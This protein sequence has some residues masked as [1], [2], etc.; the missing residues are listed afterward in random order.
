MPGRPPHSATGG[1][2]TGTA[3]DQFIAGRFGPRI[4][5]WADEL[6]AWSESPDGLTCTYLSDA[7]RAVAG[8]LCALMQKAGLTA[9]IDAVGNVVGRR[10]GTSPGARTLILGSHYDT[11]RKAGKYDGRFG[12][13]AAIAAMDDLRERGQQLPFAVEVIGFAEEEGARFPTAYLGSS[14]VA[15]KFDSA[16]LAKQDAAGTTLEEALRAAGFDPAAIAGLARPPGNLLGYVELHIEQGP[17]LRNEGLPVGVVDAIAGA[18]RFEVAISGRGGHAGTVPMAKRRDAV[19]VAAEI[20]LLVERRCSTA[21][22]LVGTVG[23]VLVPDSAVN[24]IPGRCELSLDIRA[25]EDGLRDAAIADIKAEIERIATRRK[26]GIE[27]HD[28]LQTPA[29]RCAPRL[30][31]ALAASVAHCGVP[32][33]RLVSGAGHD[34]VMFDGITDVGMLFVRCGNDGISHSADET[35]SAEDAD[36]AARVLLDFL[37]NFTTSAAF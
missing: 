34:A 15:G 36:L 13:L 12:I 7:H 23:Q 8:R 1:F 27:V 14:A 20:I 32:V 6:A 3:G 11:V 26:V 28:M 25:A 31:S 30:Q 16:V 18:T 5:A 29:V 4:L 37:T 10:E 2:V 22:G 35:I 17:V 33:R 21:A 24:A 19:A 9:V